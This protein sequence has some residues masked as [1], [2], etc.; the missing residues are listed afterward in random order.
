MF[1]V[2]KWEKRE[3]KD[4]MIKLP[5]RATK[6]ACAYD[7]YSPCSVSIPVGK[8][9]Q[10]WTDV[11]VKLEDNQVCILN[12]RSSMGKHFI[13]LANTQGWVDAD[14]YGSSSNDGN[15]GLTLFN[16]GNKP[17]EIKE[18]D[19]IA[20]AMIV[21]FDTFNDTVDTVRTGGH[22]STGV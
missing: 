7:I 3:H 16:L 1:E 15:I 14:Y 2:V 5:Q 9:C 12:V 6:S 19:R 4:A 8:A 13:F 17:Y 11:K 18:G 20:Q 22:G 10:I 21:R